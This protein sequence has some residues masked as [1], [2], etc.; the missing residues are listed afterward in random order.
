MGRKFVDC[1]EFPG[2]IKCSLAL[3]ADSENELLEAAVLHAV[4]VHKH[5]DT[6]E[7]RNELRNAI[8]EGTPPA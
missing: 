6:P 1:R 2:E 5:Q 4:T 8:R 3:I 7:L